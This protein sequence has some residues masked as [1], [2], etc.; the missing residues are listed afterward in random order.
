MRLP[1][2]ILALA[3]AVLLPQAWA[4][5]SIRNPLGALST[6]QNATILT[7]KH[8]VTALSEFDLTFNIQNDLLVKLRLEPNHDILAEDATISY[9]SSDG[10]IRHSE[11]I[12]RLAHKVYKGTAWIQRPS[13]GQQRWQNVGWARVS[14]SRDGE[15]PQFEGAFAVHH[16]SHHIQSLSN[17]ART[18]HPQDPEI[19][20]DGDDVMVIWRDSDILRTAG[21]PGHQD[22]RRSE[23]D[24]GD[25]LQCQADGLSFNL[26]PDHPV[27]LGMSKREVS[28]NGMMDFTH[29][30]GKRQVDSTTGGN[31][32]GVNLVSTIGNT[33]GCP[34]TRKVALVGVA[35]DCTYTNS[36]NSTESTRQN[37]ISQMNTAS[38]LYE[39]TFN[40]S[41][42]L[43]NLTVSDAS[44]PGTPAQAT[45]WNQ[46]CSDSVDIQA[47]LNYFSAWRGQQADNNSHWTL[48][49]TCNT[50][51]AVGLAWLGQA[52]V[53]NANTV[54]SSTTGNG[55]ST[56]AGS[57]TVAGANVVIRT[58]GA[59]EWQ[60][61]AHETGHTFGAVHDC[62][63]TTCADSNTVNSQQC[64]P[65]SSS[66][67]DAGQQYIMNPSTSEGIS[68]F[69]P[70]SI[71][72]ICSA[73]GRQS[74]KSSCFSDNKQV[75]TITGQQCGN[76]I[77][78]PGED[79]D[80]GGTGGCGSNKCCDATTCKFKS[81]AVCDDANED[82]CHNCQMATNGTVCRA[83]TGLCDPLE[84]CSGFSA[85]C[86]SDVTAPNGQSCGSGGL[87]CASGQCT[88]RDQQ[89]KTV[90]G[91][92]TQGNDTYACDSSGCAISCG[93]PEFGSGV[94]YGLQQNFLDGTVCGGSGHCSNGQCKGSTPSG[95]IKSWIDD[96]KP[97]VIGLAAG[98]GG[99]LVLALLSCLI[100]ACRRGNR[101][102]PKGNAPP[103]PPPGGWQGWQSHG[104]PGPQMEHQGYGW[105]DHQGNQGGWGGPPPPMPA[106]APR[107]GGGVRYA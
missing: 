99:L 49:S 84:T 69:S 13:I 45:E 8:R 65:L 56:G 12:E 96:H 9:L 74:V 33:Q 34:T 98:I 6:V 81:N 57:E 79:C 106:Y 26:Q 24:M 78:E 14:I 107:G 62:T 29:L 28:K 2:D 35:T 103:I 77:V 100:S 19:G 80:C 83:S 32:A 97:L 46:A 53:D 55:Q 40:I 71:G 70:C 18:R 64:C 87:Q 60:I 21:Q 16:D 37:V 82:C 25:M 73:F 72:N 20:V 7:N 76:G 30:F 58:Q 104:P 48:L 17:H 91:T 36:F 85:T 44:C 88:S 66:T 39:S 92:Y 61:I 11:S 10:T 27:Y 59:N 93:S 51:S 90:M 38:Q 105:V 86:P 101:R 3:A 63:S 15:E 102:G 52:C 23:I 68:H 67:C 42:G 4:S 95:Q 54:N 41:L 5:S 89:C 22:L 94:C 50:G 75:T 47:R 31:S 43:Q 1:F